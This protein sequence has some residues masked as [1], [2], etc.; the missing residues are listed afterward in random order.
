MAVLNPLKV[1][2]E[3]Y[4]CLRSAAISLNPGLNI[5]VGDNEAGKSTFLEAV[6]L[7]LTGQLNGRSLRSQLHPHLF[8]EDV[9]KEFCTEVNSG[10]S[11]SPPAIWAKP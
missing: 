9:V 7:A 10:R 4:R 8:N 5:G 2:I 11:A 1:V 3:N 6:H